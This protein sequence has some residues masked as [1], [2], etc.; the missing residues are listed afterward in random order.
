MKG[1]ILLIV[2]LACSVAAGNAQTKGWTAAA[3]FQADAIPLN[4]H[5]D[6][7]SVGMVIAPGYAFS[8]SFFTRLQCDLTV[9][10]WDDG[11]DTGIFNRNMTLGPAVGYNI[12]KN[13]PVWGIVDISAAVGKTLQNKNRSY[14]FYDLGLGWA[15]VPA[16]DKMKMQLGIGIRYTDSHNRGFDDYCSMYV[17]LGWRFN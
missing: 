16:R 7:S 17:K 4:G 5:K 15:F 8:P 6:F 10:M 9:G 3:W 1:S 12:I 13:N 11:V 2:L 14:H